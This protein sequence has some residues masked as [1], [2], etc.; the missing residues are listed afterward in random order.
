MLFFYQIKII[1]M[2]NYPF[3]QTTWQC[4]E[5][6]TSAHRP[7]GTLL[8]NACHS[9]IADRR[10]VSRRLEAEERVHCLEA[11]HVQAAL[12]GPAPQ[13]LNKGPP[14]PNKDHQQPPT[15]TATSLPYSS[16]SILCNVTSD[17]EISEAISNIFLCANS[18]LFDFKN[19]LCVCVCVLASSFHW[20]M[21]NRCHCCCP[22]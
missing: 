15:S 10:R 22:I 1:I 2:D 17:V 21:P 4:K 13:L 20:P 8:P 18:C 7:A 11:E 3:W 5:G 14:L 6:P 9:L 16:F 19:G 12:E